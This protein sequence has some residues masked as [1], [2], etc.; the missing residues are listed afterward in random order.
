MGASACAGEGGKG[1][2][3][4]A[5]AGDAAGDTDVST[6]DVVSLTRAQVRDRI[7][8]G[9]VGQMVGVVA[10][11]FTEFGYL[12]R[13][14]PENEVPD[15]DPFAFF[16]AWLQD[17]LY[18]EIPFLETM[19]L[20]GVTVGWEPLGEA[21]AA[22]EFRLW[23]GNQA[24]RNALRTGIPAPDSGHYRYN[25]HCDDIDWQIE[26][27][28]IGLLA[29]GMP[30]VAAELAWRQGHVVGYGDGVYG[31]VF[32]AAM[33]AE[34][35]V[36]TDVGQ[37]I[38]AGLAAIPKASLFRKLLDDVVDWHALHPDDWTATWQLIEDKWADTDRCPH[39]K[40]MPYNIDA[41]LNS[42]Y[43]LMGLLYGK[44][45]FW[46]SIV[47][48]MRGGQDSDCN[49]STVGSILGT[50]YGLSGIPQQYLSE[51]DWDKKF[52]WTDRSLADCV[53]MTEALARQALVLAGGRIEGV[54]DGETWV[55]PR[56]EVTPLV[57]EQWPY[58][59][60]D[61]P[62]LE[63]DIVSITGRTV[64]FDA[65]ATDADGILGYGWTFGDL[66]YGDGATAVHTYPQAGTFDAI[67]WVADTL[68]NTSWK[69]IQVT[70]P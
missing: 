15:W 21:F 4:D 2:P 11:G 53:E 62:L 16:T 28:Y 1:Q 38:E 10:A 47:I 63:A 34:A 12:G 60:N 17:D 44:G 42:A 46:D 27:D 57:L 45:D 69:A 18:V 14:I 49:P 35:F 26:A 5:V 33:H 54:G 59:E 36:T 68:G 24:A 48:S 41:K 52:E 13:M 19:A 7:E 32:V 29:P 56:E 3:A 50:M 64:T 30:R 65:S 23:H 39:G 20:H 31:G 43:V 55:L 61:A 8:G 67:V 58:E 25:E 51:L 9:W 70:V 40:D 22:T 6:A 37:V 66:S